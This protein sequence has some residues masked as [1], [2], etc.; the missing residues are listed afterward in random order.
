MG[1]TNNT[2]SNLHHCGH[3]RVNKLV[4][5]KGSMYGKQLP[6]SFALQMTHSFQ[7][8]REHYYYF[9]VKTT[10]T[11]RESEWWREWDNGREIDSILFVFIYYIINALTIWR[12]NYFLRYTIDIYIIRYMTIAIVFFTPDIT[13]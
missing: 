2:I 12:N 3:Y 10:L 8:E 7:V 9:Q 6:L 5:S 11:Q 13:T 1:R 4:C